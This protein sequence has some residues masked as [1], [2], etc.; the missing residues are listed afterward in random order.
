MLLEKVKN[1]TLHTEFISAANDKDVAQL[2]MLTVSN[3]LEESSTPQPS[4]VHT[5][6][7]EIGIEDPKEQR[8]DAKQDV[9]KPLPSMPTTFDQLDQ[10]P[11]AEV[12]ETGFANFEIPISQP[13][14]D[15]GAIRR[16]DSISINYSVL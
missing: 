14:E 10:E 15:I 6:S 3:I 5:K 7:A 11:L 16:I 13:P 12:E 1:G 4:S 9:S 8:F 2:I